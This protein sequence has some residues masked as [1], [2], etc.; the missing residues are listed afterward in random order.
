MRKAIRMA[1]VGAGPAVSC[2]PGLLKAHSKQLGIG[3]KS[4]ILLVDF[5]HR[6]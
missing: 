2:S 3:Y 4:I 6:L 1:L 5:S